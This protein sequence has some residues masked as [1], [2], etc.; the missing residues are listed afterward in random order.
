MIFHKNIILVTG[1]KT[2]TPIQMN[3]LGFFINEPLVN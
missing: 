2:K 3:E 1:S